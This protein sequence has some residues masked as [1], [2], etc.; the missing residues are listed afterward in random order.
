MDQPDTLFTTVVLLP[1]FGRLVLNVIKCEAETRAS[2]L[3]V[4]C[5]SVTIRFWIELGHA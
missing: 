1:K 5:S 2:S 4:S 3:S